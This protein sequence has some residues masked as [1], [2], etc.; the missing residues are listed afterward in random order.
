[1]IDRVDFDKQQLVVLEKLSIAMPN[2]DK[3]LKDM[4]Q[5][6]VEHLYQV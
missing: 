5:M 2:S 3:H 4:R 6:E 1:M